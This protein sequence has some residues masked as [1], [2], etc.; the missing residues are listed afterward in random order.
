[1]VTNNVIIT[2]FFNH[3]HISFL[4][5]LLFDLAYAGYS[6]AMICIMVEFKT[7]INFRLGL[8]HDVEKVLQ[9]FHCACSMKM[10]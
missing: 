8:K 7:E 1:M 2:G 3:W 4:W 6:K 10:S 5:L 9:S